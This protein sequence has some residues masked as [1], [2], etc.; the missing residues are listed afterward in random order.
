MTIPPSIPPTIPPP[1]IPT[2]LPSLDDSKKIDASRWITPQIDMLVS[3]G[4]ENI[5]VLE[6]TCS[7]EMWVEIKATVDNLGPA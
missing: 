7:H 5:G 3:L 6:S 1:T 2:S 4:Q